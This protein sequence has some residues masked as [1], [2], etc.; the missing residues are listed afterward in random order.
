PVR[1]EVIGVADSEPRFPNDSEEHRRQNRRVEILV[2]Q[3]KPTES[4]G[5]E[6]PSSTSLSPAAPV[7]VS[8][9]AAQPTTST[10]TTATGTAVT[11]SAPAADA[12]P[13]SELSF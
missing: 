4:G 9:P 3:G 7:P 11:D 10:G 1:L 8:Q 5:L 6:I 13:A 2:L 12:T